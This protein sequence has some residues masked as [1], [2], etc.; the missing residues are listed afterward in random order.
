MRFVPKWLHDNSLSIT[1]FAL[2]VGAL[3]GNGFSGFTSHNQTL[4]RH[5]LPAAHLSH[6][7]T[8][9]VF[10]DGI[11]VNW[12]AAILQLGCLILFGTKLHQK[13]AAHSRIPEGDSDEKRK[14]ERER[15]DRYPWVYRNSLS[16]AFAI[17]FAASLIAHI[18]FGTWAFN[19]TGALSGQAPISVGDYLLTGAFWFETMQTWQAEFLIIA[20]Y[21]ILSIFLRQQGSPESKPVYDSNEDTGETNK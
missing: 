5:G 7:L 14:K 10:L 19:E 6:Y 17:M 1:F 9:G 11:F 3:I 13:G 4:M 15:A 20:V 16:I 12:Q 21:V 18:V 8:T 2:F